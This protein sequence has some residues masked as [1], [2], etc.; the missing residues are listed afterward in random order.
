MIFGVGPLELAV[1]LVVAL[2][3]FVVPIAVV[4]AVVWYLWSHN[5]RIEHLEQGRGMDADRR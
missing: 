5:N 2:L 1:I 4:G 3:I